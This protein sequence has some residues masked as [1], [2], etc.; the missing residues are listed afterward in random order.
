VSNT[1]PPA[2]AEPTRATRPGAG[3]GAVQDPL[4]NAFATAQLLQMALVAADRAGLIFAAH[5][6]AQRR[7]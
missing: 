6:M 3:S 2:A 4:G 1:D 5:L 7:E